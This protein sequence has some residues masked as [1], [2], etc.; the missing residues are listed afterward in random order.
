[1]FVLS[2]EAPQYVSPY[3]APLRTVYACTTVHD[4]EKSEATIAC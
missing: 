3:S 2:L 1:M 4:N